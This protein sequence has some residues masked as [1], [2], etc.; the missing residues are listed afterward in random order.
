M[1][2]YWGSFIWGRALRLWYP[3]RSLSIDQECLPSLRVGQH[4][5]PRTVSP[6]SSTPCW[7]SFI[8]VAATCRFR[9]LQA[10][11]PL[12]FRGERGIWGLCFMS[13]S[14]V[15]LSPLTGQTSNRNT[16][17]VYGILNGLQEENKKTLVLPQGFHEVPPNLS[18][19]PLP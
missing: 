14:F 17:Q 2:R 11:P 18:Q 7:L 13:L 16:S 12:R 3:Y 1:G 9:L 15:S 10:K 19:K 4:P 5:A 6:L 8:G